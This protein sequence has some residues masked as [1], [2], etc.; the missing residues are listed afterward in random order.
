MADVK[1]F[2]KSATT[3]TPVGNSRS[4]LEKMLLRYGC[5]SFAS[6]CDYETGR[7][8]VS[9]EVPD[10][11]E[12][13][14]EQ[15]PVRLEVNSRNVYDAMFGRPMKRDWNPTTYTNGEPYHNPKGYDAKLLAQA[16][17]VAWRQIL[18]WVDAALSAASA[19]IQRISEAFLAHTLVQDANGRAVRMVDYMDAMAGGRWQ[20]KLLPP[21]PP[22]GTDG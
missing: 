12:K 6:Q 16:E 8:A 15:I 19:G 17:R 1:R 3:S 14:A 13:G 5:S 2:V 9:F 22:G 21:P 10:T 18:L 20:T 7:I 11:L 4:E